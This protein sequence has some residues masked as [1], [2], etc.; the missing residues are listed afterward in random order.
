[1]TFPISPE[2]FIVRSLVR[3]R[4]YLCHAFSGF[5]VLARNVLVR[6]V[7]VLRH[8]S[9]LNLYLPEPMPSFLNSAEPQ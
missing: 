5:L 8:P 3:K 2:A 6:A 7:N 9:H 4:T 1:M